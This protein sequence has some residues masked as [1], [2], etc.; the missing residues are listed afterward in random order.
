MWWSVWQQDKASK[1]LSPPHPTPSLTSIGQGHRNHM[2]SP[3]PIDITITV[4]SNHNHHYYDHSRH[5]YCN[6]LA[7]IVE[8]S[9]YLKGALS[10][11]SHPLSFCQNHPNSTM[12][13]SSS[14]SLYAPYPQ[15]RHS[16]CQYY[17]HSLCQLLIAASQYITFHSIWFVPLSTPSLSDPPVCPTR[18]SSSSSSNV[19]GE[20]E[21]R[22]EGDENM[23]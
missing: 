3:S 16:L 2:I 6:L 12:E 9:E 23:T 13:F 1:L 7:V 4:T 18:S 5:D 21:G 8:S 10:L 15:H 17:Y 14:S 20:G 19:E 11:S 22:R